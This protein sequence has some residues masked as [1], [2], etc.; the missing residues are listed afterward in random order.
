MRL[1]ALQRPPSLIPGD[2]P[3]LLAAQSGP[4]AHSLGPVPPHL[5]PSISAGAPCFSPTPSVLPFSSF[6][7]GRMEMGEPQNH[8]LGEHR[9]LVPPLSPSHPRACLQH[10]SLKDLTALASSFSAAPGNKR[11]DSDPRSPVSPLLALLVN[12]VM[13]NTVLSPG[14]L[15]CDVMFWRLVRVC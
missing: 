14:L 13:R 6:A 12:G 11:S 9:L 3:A 15:L 8:L 4:S 7:L 5:L 10:S 2:A 1:G